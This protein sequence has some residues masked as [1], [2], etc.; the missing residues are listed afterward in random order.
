LRHEDV[1][2]IRPV[3]GFSRH[4]GL[5]KRKTGG[6]GGAGWPVVVRQIPG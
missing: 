6:S 1:S 3:G 4:S 5:H 2:N